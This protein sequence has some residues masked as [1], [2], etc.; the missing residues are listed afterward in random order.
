MAKYFSSILIFSTIPLS[1]ANTLSL[2]FFRLDCLDG[3][4]SEILLLNYISKMKIKMINITN[5]VSIFQPIQV[6][7]ISM[8]ILFGISTALIIT[9]YIKFKQNKLRKISNNGNNPNCLISNNQNYSREDQEINLNNILDDV[10]ESLKV[11]ECIELY[12]NKKIENLGKMPQKLII[13]FAMLENHK[14]LNKY[15]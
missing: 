5:R 2:L 12:S 9:L 1:I 11:P 10:Y 13:S 8:L 6:I 3:I 4:I 14:L 7:V 15:K